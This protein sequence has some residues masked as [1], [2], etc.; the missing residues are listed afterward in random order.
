MGYLITGATGLIGRHLLPLLAARGEPVFV[1]VRAVA[2]ERL[3]R[4]LAGCGARRELVVPIR[5][6]LRLD[7]LG[8]SVDDLERL[9]GRVRHFFHLAALYDL[10]AHAEDLQQAN[11]QGTRHALEL[12]H[13]LQAGCFHLVSSIAVA[14]RYRGRFTESMFAEAGDLDHPYFSSKHESE[15]LVRGSC[16]I[17]WRIYRPGMVVGHS[18]TG[19]M[20][21]VDGPYYLFKPIQKLRALVPQWVA[22]P[23]YRGGFI[24]LVPVD[25]VAA[26]LDHLAHIPGQDARCFHLTSEDRRLGET[27]NVFAR[28]AHAPTM[29]LTPAAS[30]EALSAALP[31]LRGALPPVQ[32]VLEQLLVDLQVPRS[33]LSLLNYPTTFDATEARRLLEPA[34]IRPPKLEDYAWRLWDYWERELDADAHRPQRLQRAVAG[35]RILV[36]GGSSGIGRATAVKLAAAGARVLIVGRDQGKLDAVRREIEASE[37]S[38]RTYTC[39]LTDAPACDRFLAQLLSEHTY[40]DILIN[41]AGRSIRRSIDHAYDRLHDYER[42]MRI[43][44][45]AAVRVTLALLP[46]MVARGDGHIVTLSSIGVLSNAPRF[47]AYNASKAALEAFSRCAAAE[48]KGRG[49]HFTVINMPLV[50]T[51]MVAPTRLYEQ[52]KLLEPEEAAEIVCDALVRRP[53]RLTTR[54]GLLSLAVE[55]VSPALGRAIMSESF[56]LFP[57]SSAAGQPSEAA[58]PPAD[59]PLSPEM[60]SLAALLH[61]VHY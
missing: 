47:S 29:R 18:M 57:E 39:D 37:G 17:P 36:T 54:L 10:G 22:L 53:E 24:N 42:L 48:F 28:A 13:E 27:V 21:K 59:T 41:N 43:N 49:V 9:R 8:V 58:H 11:V 31:L 51:P 26:A 38:V 32:R 23:I 6:D 35:K 15:A 44:Y 60:H 40:V 20:D 2:A 50:R 4:A 5:G 16:R 61:G 7:C 12:A 3:E 45:H 19:V 1:L 33:A 25:F 30:W 34:G 55:L 56:R 14:G 52:F 46:S